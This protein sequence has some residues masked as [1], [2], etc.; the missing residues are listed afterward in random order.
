MKI[1]VIGMGKIGLPLAV[2]YARK[3]HDVI[4]VDINSKTVDLINQ[5]KEPFP[6]EAHLHEYLDEVI[7]LK[8]MK[9]TLSYEE[10][11]SHADAVVVVV[12]LIVNEIFQPNFEAIDSATAKIGKYLKA[13]ALVCYETTLPIGT[14]RKRFTPILEANSGFE[15][16]KDFS[17]V[18]SPERVFTGRIFN[19]L[20]RYPKIVGGVTPSCTQKGLEFYRNLL[21]FDFREDLVMQNGV[22]EVDSAECAEF[23]KLAETTYR[24]VN[25]ALANQFA[26]HAEELGVNIYEVI[27]AANSQAFSHIHDPGLSVGGHCI[28][29]YPHFYLSTNN[30]AKIVEVARNLNKNMPRHVVD[31]VLKYLKESPSGK[32]LILGVSYRSNVKEAAFSGVFDLAQEFE[33]NNVDAVVEDSLFSSD[34]ILNLGL[35]VFEGDY[36]S[37]IGIVVH[38]LH[39]NDVPINIEKFINCKFIFDGRNAL[40]S[41]KEENLPFVKLTLGIGT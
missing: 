1:A 30:D 26:L 21:D 27:Q 35:K 25:I 37:I 6:E 17:V 13:N 28:P 23:V 31:R 18:F 3:G 20:R 10:A 2:Q 29:V 22:W 15:V 4:G 34:E 9:A 8:R 33:R 39:A 11:V 32:I 38:T 19:D 40:S 5:G 12:P 14:T 7:A 41:V 16:G 36:D 24:D